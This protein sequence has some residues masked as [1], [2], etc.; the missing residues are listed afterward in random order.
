VH[1]K[2]N[3]AKKVAGRGPLKARVKQGAAGTFLLGDFWQNQK[4]RDPKIG[5]DAYVC[6]PEFNS[7]QNRV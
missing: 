7:L 2:A 5:F 3:L 4:K 6:G 1:S